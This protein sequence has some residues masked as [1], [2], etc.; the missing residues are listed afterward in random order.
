MGKPCGKGLSEAAKGAIIKA[1]TVSFAPPERTVKTMNDTDMKSGEIIAFVFDSGK[2]EDCFYG[3]VVF[4]CM[5]SGKEVVKNPRKIVVS[6]GDIADFRIFDDITPYLIRNELCTIKRSRES[7]K[8]NLFVMLLE[9]IDAD[10]ARSIDTR[11]QE[12][13]AAY[14]GMTPIDPE[15]TDER[16]QFWKSLIR[17]FSIEHNSVT[18]FGMA[19]EE[20]FDY[21]EAASELG[22]HISYDNF[23]FEID[24]YDDTLFST[25]QSTVIR[26][27]AQ[28]RVVAGQ[29]DSDRGILEMNY[30]L[31][32]EVEIAGVQIWKAME[33]IDR[34]AVSKEDS[35]YGG[36]ITD[37]LFTSLYQAS[38]G[39][40]RLL[41]VILELYAYDKTDSAE[42]KRIN[43]LL[44]SHN[45]LAM[46]D[47]LSEKSDLK[48]K[49]ACKKLLSAL[50]AFYA[51]ARYSRYSYSSNR[52]LEL[53]I[54]RD[55]GA[56]IDS[57]NFDDAV[58]HLY[59]RAMAQT[60][61]ALYKF[62]TKLSHKLNIFVYELNSDSTAQLSLNSYYGDDLYDLL[63]RIQQSKKEL[64]WYL[65]QEGRK[66][67]T[68]E[69]AGDLPA[70]PF[71]SCD[72]PELLNDLITN[73]HSCTRL[74]EF[75]SDAYD[76]LVEED[77]AA[78]KSRIEAIDLLVGNTNVYFERFDDTYD[79][80]TDADV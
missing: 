23:P 24:G 58:K 28:L 5:F 62:I 25:R 74:Y 75:V 8:D 68:A 64:I 20:A 41:K 37:Y 49:P 6:H 77:K 7:F 51:K 15:S 73:R 50:T 14:V 12:E 35:P 55:F 70:L 69:F 22:F 17:C 59:G 65:M 42:K 30:S 60:S 10:I 52:A 76:E 56:D 11:L 34:V 27:V 9:D 2:I 71:E 54:L 66:L 53:T 38:Q 16:K 29:S 47:F 44:F 18:A 33:D 31:V 40:E 63:K 45:H 72:I 46:V 80:S 39:M 67:P 21:C 4:T 36:A 48:L 43:N 1:A 19:E 13:L 79:S 26:S 3:N 32:K 61:H 57:R 78:W